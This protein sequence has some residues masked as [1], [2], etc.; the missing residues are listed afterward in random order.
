MRHSTYVRA[1]IS[2]PVAEC[3]EVA[4][5]STT[6]SNLPILEIRDHHEWNED[7]QKDKTDYRECRNVEKDKAL[8]YCKSLLS[9][10]NDHEHQDPSIT[11]PL[12]AHE[13]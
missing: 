10:R 8:S 1:R 11:D 7:F 13:L 2:F 3:P 6:I 4:E 12:L 5:Y 9:S